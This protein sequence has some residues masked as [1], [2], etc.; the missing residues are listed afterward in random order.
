MISIKKNE[1]FPSWFQISAFGEFVDEIKG[2]AQA[3][4]FARTLA[5]KKGQAY[6]NAFGECEKVEK[7]A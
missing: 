6:I 3:M 7:N 5:K 4:K 1:N 2:Q